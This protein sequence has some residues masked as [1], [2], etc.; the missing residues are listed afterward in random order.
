MAGVDLISFFDE[1]LE[2]WCR[3][4]SENYHWQFKVSV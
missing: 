4:W 3:K 2:E 1:L